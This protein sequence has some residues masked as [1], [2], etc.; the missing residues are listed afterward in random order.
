MK[1]NHKKKVASKRTPI[2]KKYENS[3][4]I[5]SVLVSGEVLNNPYA[6]SGVTM[7]A[8]YFIN[9]G[10]GKVK[11][12]L[13]R[14]DSPLL[15]ECKFILNY[16]ENKVCGAEAEVLQVK[17]EGKDTIIHRCSEFSAHVAPVADRRKMLR[18]KYKGKHIK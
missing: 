3:Q 13:K 6:V 7:A 4:S 16:P 17:I 9:L 10:Y 2:I 14:Y 11:A 5:R 8:T 1:I 12:H 15:T 18:L